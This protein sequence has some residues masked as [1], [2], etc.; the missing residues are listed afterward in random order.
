[1]TMHLRLAKSAF[2]FSSRF[3]VFLFVYV[4]SY[5][6]RFIYSCCAYLSCVAVYSPL[7]PVDVLFLTEPCHLHTAGA[8]CFKKVLEQ[9]E[10]LFVYGGRHT[11]EGGWAVAIHLDRSCLHGTRE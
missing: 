7:L 5:S 2:P 1:M 8:T 3:N 6:I 11:V 9:A 4:V 10:A